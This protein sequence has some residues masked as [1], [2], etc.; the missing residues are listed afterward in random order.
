MLC[1]DWEKKANDMKF[2][3]AK[4]KYTWRVQKDCCVE[5]VDGSKKYRG[6]VKQVISAPGLYGKE[7]SQVVVKTTEDLT[8]TV[9]VAKIRIVKTA[10]AIRKDQHK[11]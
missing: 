4:H 1:G 3:N 9:D 6:V 11:G 5:W 7:P 8:F 2:D 10:N